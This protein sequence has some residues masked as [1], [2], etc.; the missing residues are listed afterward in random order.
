MFR[1]LS[2]GHERLSRTHVFAKCARRRP[3]PGRWS[4]GRSPARSVGNE[5]DDLGGPLPR[6]D[7]FLQ[8]YLQHHWV[9]STG[10]RDL[11]DRAATMTDELAGAIARVLA[12]ASSMHR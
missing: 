3:R 4:A 2:A 1:L 10:G 11:F 9:G 5:P 6:D 7:Q 12:G 8:I